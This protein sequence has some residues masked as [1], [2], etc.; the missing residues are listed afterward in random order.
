M[1]SL[2]GLNSSW[3]L[4]HKIWT[5]RKQRKKKEEEE[6]WA[7]N[8]HA[9]PWPGPCPKLPPHFLPW[10]PSRAHCQSAHYGGMTELMPD[11]W[12]HSFLCLRSL[13]FPGM[14][15]AFILSRRSQLKWHLLCTFPAAHI[16]TLEAYREEW[17]AQE[18]CANVWSLSISSKENVKTKR[19]PHSNTRPWLLEA[20]REGG[21]QKDVGMAGTKLE[22]CG[23]DEFL[24]PNSAV[25]IR[26]VTITL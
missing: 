1:S 14:L 19:T 13:F 5:A 10:L 16:L 8:F 23:R 7:R 9:A 24:V 17:H 21:G 18:C 25:G 26:Q 4:V 22:L 15:V 6:I 12:L 3:G 11:L 20:G 2:S